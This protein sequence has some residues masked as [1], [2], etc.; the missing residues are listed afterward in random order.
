MPINPE[1][2]LAHD[3]GEI[4]H[5]YGARDAI[6]Y[7]L[8]IGL[9]RDPLDDN[10]LAFLDETR[11]KVMPSFAV[12]LSSPGMWI[13]D[14]SFG[15]NFGK[16]VH[17]A[18]SAWFHNQLPAEAQVVGTAKVMQLTD[19]GE[20]RGAELV[21]KRL[22]RDGDSGL[23]YCSLLQTLLLRGDGG[24]GGPPTERQVSVIPDRKPDQEFA[25]ETSRRAALIYRLSGDWN[26]LHINPETA[27]NAGFERPI[28]QGLA[29]YG[30]ASIAVARA[31][32][33]DPE[34]VSHL[35]CRFAGTVTPGDTLHFTIWRTD[36][37]ATFQ[38]FVGD[39]KV[40]DEG[41]IQW[42]NI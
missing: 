37:G 16:L 26:P 29:S 22:I 3:F 5:R 9:G 1:T 39:R 18:Q 17:S 28:L 42:T 33:M 4:R 21:L 7:A 32:G 34:N 14:P 20:G 25:F 27:R 8:G 31:L 38:A 35:T 24:F 2:L 30:I 15:I 13:R 11:L 6:L 41:Q 36:G 10:D 40:L 19:R 12:T 23:L